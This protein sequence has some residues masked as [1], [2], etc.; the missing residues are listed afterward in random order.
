[1][2]APRN[3]SHFPRSLRLAR[4]VLRHHPVQ[5]YGSY[6]TVRDY[7]TDDDAAAAMIAA[8]R[9]GAAKARVLVTIVAAEQS[10]TI[11]EIVSTFNRVARRTPCFVTSAT[12]LLYLYSRRATSFNRSPCRGS[13]RG[14]GH[15][16]PAVFPSSWRQSGLGTRKA[17]GTMLL[18]NIKCFG[19]YYSQAIMY[20]RS[21]ACL[22]GLFPESARVDVTFCECSP[23]VQEKND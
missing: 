6:E 2:C 23:Q 16:W 3:F 22:V 4:S 8:S 19:F 11:V 20:N 15:H 10:A 12:R 18:H 17:T 13:R 14:P 1:M 21:E 5:I 7:I 9:D